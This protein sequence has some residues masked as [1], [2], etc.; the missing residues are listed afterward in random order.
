[1]SCKLHNNKYQT[2]SNASTQVTNTEIFALIAVLVLKL[3]N[4]KVLFANRKDNRNCYKVDFS[5]VSAFSIYM[6]VPLKIDLQKK[7]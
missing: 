7:I 1:M 4:R 6:T 2:H 3:F 5:F